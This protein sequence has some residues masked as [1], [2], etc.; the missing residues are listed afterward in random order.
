MLVMC[1]SVELNSCR[2]CSGC[3]ALF[4]CACSLWLRAVLGSFANLLSRCTGVLASCFTVLFCMY[5]DGRTVWLR[6]DI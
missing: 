2:P 6:R 3:C 4:A 5:A 1:Q